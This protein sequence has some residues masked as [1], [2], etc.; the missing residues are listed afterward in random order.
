MRSAPGHKEVFATEEVVRHAGQA[1]ASLG[2]PFKGTWCREGRSPND[3]ERRC[4]TSDPLDRQF[5]VNG[6]R[7]LAFRPAQQRAVHC[8][9][10]PKRLLS[11]SMSAAFSTW[12]VHSGGSHRAEPDSLLLRPHLLIPAGILPLESRLH[13]HNTSARLQVSKNV[14]SQ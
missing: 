3:G 10:L 8:L 9:C 7:A 12:P 13:P 5:N 1:N 6:G 4:V 2:V 14:N 11:P